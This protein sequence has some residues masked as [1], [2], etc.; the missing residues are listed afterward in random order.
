[1]RA[2]AAAATQATAFAC[3]FAGQQELKDLFGLEH[4]TVRLFCIMMQYGM[5]AD[6]LDVL[7]QH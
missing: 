1:M 3:V 6:A 2:F 4:D 5:P 7:I